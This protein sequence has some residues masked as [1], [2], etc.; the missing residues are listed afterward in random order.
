MTKL[1]K[2]RYFFYSL[3]FKLEIEIEVKSC[4]VFVLIHIQN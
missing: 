2:I 1:I 4:Y 3:D